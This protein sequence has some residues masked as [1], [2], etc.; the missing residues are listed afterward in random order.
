MTLQPPF[1]GY[2][3]PFAQHAVAFGRRELY[4]LLRTAAHFAGKPARS[5]DIS[6]FLVSD[7]ILTHNF[8]SDSERSDA[9]RDYQQVLPELGLIVSTEVSSV[10]TL[11]PAGLSLLD[12]ALGVSETLTNQA[13]KYQYPNGFKWTISAKVRSAMGKGGTSYKTLPEAHA[14]HGVLI[15]P[16]VLLLRYLL[17]LTADG[18]SANISEDECAGFAIPVV[19][20]QDWHVG[21][22]ALVQSRTVR[23][24][25][26]RYGSRRNIQDWF[27]FLGKT[28]I[29]AV[30][31]SRR[32]CLRPEILGRIQH[33]ATLC[34]RLEDAGSFWIYSKSASRLSWFDHFGG[35]NV[36]SQ[37]AAENLAQEYVE[38]NYPEGPEPEESDRNSPLTAD[39]GIELRSYTPPSSAREKGKKTTGQQMID[40]QKVIAEIQNK[41]RLHNFILMNL[42]SHL[43][44]NGYT[45]KTSMGGQ[46]ESVD[47]LAT[48][49]KQTAI[50]EVKTLNARNWRSRLRLGVG[51][52]SEYRYRWEKKSGVRPDA[53]LVLSVDKTFPSW[54]I[55]FFETDAKMGL[56]GFRDSHFVSYTNTPADRFI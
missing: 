24:K 12:G 17:T 15:R 39:P 9:W 25:Y 36:D 14:A 8:R 29:F 2:S 35:E 48:K 40:W 45:V 55:D 54:M 56:I 7:K 44:D 51:Q 26:P 10:I 21:Y 5:G 33:L 6:S 50:F 49:A 46:Q 11:T 52:L 41:T 3:W 1:R 34:T 53:G 22:S 20:H 19:R 43:T 18:H 47:L 32:L 31:S 13:L 23:S 4:G 28:D 30:D 27:K 37:W 42:A 38:T 16:A